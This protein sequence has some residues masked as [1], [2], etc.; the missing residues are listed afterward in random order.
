MEAT[1]RR[2]P[3]RQP[4]VLVQVQ[5]DAPANSKIRRSLVW[6]M[7]QKNATAG[8]SRRSNHSWFAGPPGHFVAAIRVDARV[9][10]LDTTCIY[11]RPPDPA[12]G[13]Y[14][15]VTCRRAKMVHGMQTLDQ[16]AAVY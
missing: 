3:C 16:L 9:R 13:Q 10:K 11:T 4:Q 5:C 8:G 2:L 6:Q 7:M 15:L 14:A 12:T 1:L